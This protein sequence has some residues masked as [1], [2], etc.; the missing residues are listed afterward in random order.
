MHEALEAYARTARAGAGTG[1]VAEAHLGFHRAL[2][3]SHRQ[4]RLVAV[5]E[6]LHG[7]LRLALAGV[8]RRRGNIREQ[9]AAHRALLEVIE[10]GDVEAAVEA[11]REHLADAEQS[12]GEAVTR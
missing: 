12:I 5:A 2:V 4:Q 9:V 6:A 10:S 3:G 1:P 7:E 11:I 8:D